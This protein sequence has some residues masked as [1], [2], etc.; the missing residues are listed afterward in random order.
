MLCK[1]VCNVFSFSIAQTYKFCDDNEAYV[2]ARYPPISWCAF[3]NLS[4]FKWSADTFGDKRMTK[5]NKVPIV[6]EKV[7]CHDQVFQ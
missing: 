4:F 2:A 6:L 3:E 7:T 5:R 1:D